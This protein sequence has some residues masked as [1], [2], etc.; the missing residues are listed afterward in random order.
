VVALTWSL[1]AGL[2]GGWLVLSPWALGERTS[3]GDWTS[4]ATTE[5]YSGL[6][7]VALALICLAA[8][9][10]QVVAALRGR[11]P[12]SDR[13][14]AKADEPAELENALVAVAQAL[15]ADL[16]SKGTA[17][18]GDHEVPAPERTPQPADSR[19]NGGRRDGW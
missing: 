17:E 13:S 18:G 8:I 14:K 11:P 2:V 19:P 4:T 7:L 1:I 9:V 6:G 3:G 16:A 12:R 5:F 10:V 15:A